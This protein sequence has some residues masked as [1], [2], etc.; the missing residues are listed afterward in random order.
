[1]KIDLD[2]LKQLLEAFEASETPYIYL[3]D[4]VKT[5]PI[6]FDDA[7]IFHMD[8]LSDKG[9]ICQQNGDTDFGFRMG[10]NGHVMRNI[11]PLRLTAEGHEFLTALK[12]KE[13]WTALKNNF[14]EASIGTLAEAGKSLL[15]AFTKKKVQDLTGLEF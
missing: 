10:L 6:R 12:D 2:Y 1:M 8:I 4:V 11:V 15:K 5:T 14:K 7:L 3:S 13:V 9:L